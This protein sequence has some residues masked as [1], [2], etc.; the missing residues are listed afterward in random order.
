MHRQRTHQS[1][2]EPERS[3][4][5]AVTEEDLAA[6]P[7]A[8]AHAAADGSLTE[9]D[10]ET[11][12]DPAL[13]GIPRGQG[14]MMLFVRIASLAKSLAGSPSN[15]T[16]LLELG[17]MIGALPASCPIPPLRLMFLAKRKRF[18]QL[19][20]AVTKGLEEHSDSQTTKL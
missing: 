17:F 15:P 2:A 6:E 11:K 1:A 19:Q 8:G 18:A 14:S 10:A 12:V 5:P 20:F 9:G 4:L 7:V 3:P 16:A 13:D